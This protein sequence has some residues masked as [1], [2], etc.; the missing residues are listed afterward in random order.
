MFFIK[1]PKRKLSK[2]SQIFATVMQTKTDAKWVQYMI[3]QMIA[4]VLICNVLG[5]LFY[6]SL[7]S[8]YHIYIFSSLDQWD[9]AGSIGHLVF[10][11]LLILYAEKTRSIGTCLLDASAIVIKTIFI[12]MQSELYT[13]LSNENLTVFCDTQ[14]NNQTMNKNGN[15]I[16]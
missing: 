15:V 3:S 12:R 4:S 13:L 7:H 14:N 9:K 6:Q 16:Q 1:L 10:V 8:F 11:Y 5:H 2:N